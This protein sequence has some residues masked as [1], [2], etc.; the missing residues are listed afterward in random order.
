MCKIILLQDGPSLNKN[1]SNRDTLSKDFSIFIY[2]FFI[3]KL[4]LNR[5]TENSE[6]L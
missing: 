3:G 6:D 4:P 1:N 2:F 5:G